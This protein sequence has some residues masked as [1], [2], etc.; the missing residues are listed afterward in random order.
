MNLPER[1]GLEY[2]DE[3]GKRKRPVMLHRALFGSL[4]RFIGI[5]IEHY[6]GKLPAWLAPVQAVVLSI[7]DEHTAYA[8]EVAQLLNRQACAPRWMCATRRSVTK[9]VSKPCSA[10]PFTGGGRQ[11]A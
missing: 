5:L 4:E 2:V 3:D 10:S 1:F 8:Q 11:G 9:S 7:T 6:A